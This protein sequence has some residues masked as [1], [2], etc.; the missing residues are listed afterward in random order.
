MHLHPNKISNKAYYLRAD[1]VAFNLSL[2]LLNSIG[3][4]HR[5]SL[6]KICR[7]LPNFD[8]AYWT[9]GRADFGP[10][11]RKGLIAG[12][13]ITHQGM[14]SLVGCAYGQA[15]KDR[16]LTTMLSEALAGATQL[17]YELQFL[18]NGGSI[19]KANALAIYK[20][21]GQI[22]RQDILKKFNLMLEDPFNSFRENA[23]ESYKTQKIL[24]D[25]L[26]EAADGKKFDKNKIERHLFKLRQLPFLMHKDF[27]NFMLFTSTYCGFK[28]NREDQKSVED[29]LKK[30]SSGIS[31]A[32]FM[33]SLG[34]ERIIAEK[35]FKKKSI[36]THK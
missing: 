4:S 27:P 32:G 35:L 2:T 20:R 9:V 3:F 30:L 12:Y 24:L 18:N 21:S 36:G 10:P 17:Y 25:A 6:T 11:D 13:D 7:V 15:L 14:H 29:C 16:P 34:V 26:K 23:V 33:T 31:M 5:S 8:K 22:L 19:G 1:P 28:S